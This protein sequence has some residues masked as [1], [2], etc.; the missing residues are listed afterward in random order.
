MVSPPSIFLGVAAVGVVACAAPA[1]G[2]PF[3]FRDGGGAFSSSISIFSPCPRFE[4]GA[5]L[6]ILVLGIDLV[7][8]FFI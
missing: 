4:F 3:L 7:F 6:S 5:K 2:G 8:R 1:K